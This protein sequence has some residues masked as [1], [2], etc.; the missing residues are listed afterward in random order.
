MTRHTTRR[1]HRIGRATFGGCVELNGRELMAGAVRQE[2]LKT[3]M[4]RVDRSQIMVF[5]QDVDEKGR[6]DVSTR[7]PP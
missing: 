7:V 2:A 1:Q 5:A 6:F 3:W 4:T